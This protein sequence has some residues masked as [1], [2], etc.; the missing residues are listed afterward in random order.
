[1]LLGAHV[2]IGG[3][4]SKAVSSGISINADAIQVFT[5]NQ[6]QWKAKP[7]DEGDAELFKTAFRESGL[8]SVV[9][10]G[11]YLTNLASSEQTTADKSVEAVIDEIC[12]CDLLGIH[13]YVFHPGSHVGAGEEK[14]LRREAENLIKILDATSGCKVKLALET[15]AGQGNIIC[16]RLE[17]IAEV[18]KSVDSVRLGVCVDTCHIFAAGYDITDKSGFDRFMNSFR[19]TIGIRRLIAVHLNDSKTEL[20]SHVDRHENIGKG[21]IGI[22]GFRAV[23]NT[24]ALSKIPMLLETPGGERVYAREIRLLRGLVKK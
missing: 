11:S 13:T 14:G 23:M 17:S 7:I 4:F 9:A 15:M 10:H 2:G 20:G 22:A 19:K 18:L 6:M 1:M 5:R 21:K 12:R 16:S 8:K 24:D 3:G